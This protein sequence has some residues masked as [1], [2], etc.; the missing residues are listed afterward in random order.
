MF[1]WIVVG[2]IYALGA[3]AF[4]KLARDARWLRAILW[5]LFVVFAILFC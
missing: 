3:I 1:G 2:I 5:P 4:F